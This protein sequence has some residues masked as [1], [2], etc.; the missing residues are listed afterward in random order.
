MRLSITFTLA[1]PR[2][3]PFDLGSKNG[4]G[5]PV[6]NWERDAL[7]ECNAEAERLGTMLGCPSHKSP[8]SCQ[9]RYEITNGSVSISPVQV[10]G[11]RAFAAA[12]IN[13]QARRTWAASVWVWPTQKRKA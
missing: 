3:I 10:S 13:S 2:F 7:H 1:V 8:P 11:S 4:H 5:V 12:W 9:L 6:R